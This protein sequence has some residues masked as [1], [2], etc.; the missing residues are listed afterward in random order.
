VT[1]LAHRASSDLSP[2]ARS[3]LARLDSPAAR[4]SMADA[5]RR[6]ALAVGLPEPSVP[7]TQFGHDEFQTIRAKL[8]AGYALETANQSIVAI[9]Q[10]L[11]TA[12]DLDPPLVTE[13]RLRKAQRWLK[14]IPGSRKKR[15]RSIGDVEIRAMLD[16]AGK[17]S[18]PK[19]PML[20]ALLLVALGTGL[21]RAELAGLKL[22]DLHDG[23]L[24]G[25]VGKGNREFDV[26]LDPITERALADWLEVRARL[27][28][29][30][31]AI[32]GSPTRGRPLTPWNLWRLLVG[33]AKVRGE[34]GLAT[35]A[36]V[37]PFTPHD[38]RRTYASRLLDAGLD[39][40]SLQRLMH[41][42]SVETTAMYDHREEEALDR[43]RR[44]FV[45]FDPE[46][47]AC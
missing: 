5:I 33:G 30:H 46:K 42:A 20:R 4:S 15:G 41:H 12:A 39:L 28:W 7:W 2:L 34:K 26:A 1:K 27:G 8:K 14:R 37:R 9:R 31:Q 16:C 24:H 10:L 21:R 19:G 40:R 23:K 38:T 44:E 13:E 22:A 45:I 25:I 43:R 36:G 29:K 35:L 3:Y 32:F 47:K 18:S 17:L 11:Q 6:A